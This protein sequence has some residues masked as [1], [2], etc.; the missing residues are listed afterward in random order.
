MAPP[1]STPRSTTPDLPPK[2]LKSTPRTYTSGGIPLKPA[3]YS[4]VAST[5]TPAQRYPRISRPVPMMRPSYDVVVIGSG[6]GGGVS[7]SRTARAG[8]SVCVLERGQER[9]PGEYPVSGLEAL[10]QVHIS[11]NRGQS[12]HKVKDTEIGDPTALYHLVLGEGQNAFVASGLGGTSLLNANIFLEADKRTMAIESSWPDELRK[13]DSLKEYYDRARAMLQPVPYPEDHPELMKLNLLK[14]QAEKLGKA[15]KFYRPPQTTFFEDGVNAAGVEMKASTLS[16]QD[17]TGV[18]D[19]SKNSVLMNYLP[20]AWNW[21]A[22]IFCE[23]EVRYIKKDPSGTGYLVFFAWHG[24][25]R[26]RAHFEDLFYNELMWVRAKELCFLAAGT[27]GT[28]E[29]LLRS[30]ELGLQMSPR[31][32]NGMSGNGDVLAFGYNTDDIANAIGR[33]NPPEDDLHRPVG[34]TI[35][36]IIDMRGE[37]E[38]KDVLDGFVLE[39]G[40]VPEVLSQFLQAMLQLTPGK[41]YPENNASQSGY[42]RL[43]KFLASAETKIMGPYS[44]GS[45]IN[46]TQIYLIMSHDSNEATLTLEGDK[47]YLRF[48]GVGRGKHITELNKFLAK[49]T[50]AVGGVLVNSPFYAFK[51]AGLGEEEITVHPIGGANMSFDGTGEGGVTNHMG[52]VFTGE[53]AEV[54]DGLVCVDGSVIPCALGVNPFATITA[55]AERSLDCLSKKNGFTIDLETSNGKLDLLKGTPRVTWPLTQDMMEAQKSILDAAGESGVRFAEVMDGHLYVG[56]EIEDFKVA[57]KHAIG[58]GSTARFFLSVDTYSTKNLVTRSDHAS[59]ATGTFTCSALSKD[60]FMVLRG[61]VQF[62]S[63]DLSTPDTKNLMYKFDIVGTDGQLFH[64]NGYKIIDSN[65]AF[66]PSKTW[67]ATTTLYVTITRPDKSVV[68]RGILHISVK[69]FGDELKGFGANG[70]PGTLIRLGSIKRFLSFFSLQTAGYFFSPLRALRYPTP[71]AAATTSG[72]LPKVSPT[73]VITLTAQ[74]QVQSTLHCWTP[75]QHN[76]DLPPILF[77]P[78]ASVDERIFALPTIE[79]NAIEFFLGKGYR[80]Y[81][82]TH[83]VGK[84]EAAKKGYTT[85]DA[86]LDIKAAMEYVRNK[87]NQEKMYCIVHCAGSVAFSMGLLDGTIPA[88]WVKGMTASQVFF[89]PKF[90]TV[91]MLKARSPVRLPSVY[92]RLAGDWFDCVSSTNDALVQ[93]LTDQLL[94]FYP[95]GGKD[96]ICNSTT[97][98]RSELVFGRLWSHKKLN[99]ATHDYLSNMVGG[100]SMKTL[101]NLMY[102]GTHDTVMDNDGNS[103]VTESNLTRLRGLP[104]LFIHGMNNAVYTPESTEISLATL[105]DTFGPQKYVERQIFP[106]YGHLDCWMGKDAYKDIYPRVLDH[107][108]DVIRPLSNDGASATRD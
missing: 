73:S 93:R 29:I 50:H 103:L 70:A 91:N 97:C 10:K 56:D 42:N 90:A 80:L 48:L 22:E 34:P 19:G 86:R 12:T 36:G 55:L 72:L 28:T 77:V 61:E 60:P 25:K 79:T 43:R 30:K 13:P 21:G 69:N 64:F 24:N 39:E 87:A 100:V 9:W 81:V 88:S 51:Y 68:G 62:F 78:G 102:A 3:D 53:S 44:P 4:A 65:M 75:L 95:V 31:V 52:E 58:I 38:A 20:D 108:E 2:I 11:G 27:L 92:K 57:E 105:R 23:C 82:I 54:Y 15:D 96:E 85:Y 16:G 8:K 32:G 41:I 59:I 101:E 5:P 45:S 7:A 83:R 35:T 76:P 71:A 26:N 67:K 84:S 74:D 18:N 107:I 104:I 14:K 99:S 63:Q 17:C 98:H 47:A 40:A 33:Q 37:D 106:G 1:N 94:R 66:S 89:N 49:A 46:R 6:Y